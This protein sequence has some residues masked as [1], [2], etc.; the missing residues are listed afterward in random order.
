MR[1]DYV[2]RDVMVLTAPLEPR[3]CIDCD[4]TI[5]A[6]DRFFAV[7]GGGAHGLHH[8]PECPKQWTPVVMDGE[9][10]QRPSQLSLPLLS[11]A[12]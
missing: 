7:S 3:T 12:R 4:G 5:P 6:G 8:W 11:L 2:P 9:G 10:T 1:L